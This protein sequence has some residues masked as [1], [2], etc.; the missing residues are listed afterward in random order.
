M[1]K[2]FTRRHFI[3]NGLRGLV[4]LLLGKGFYNSTSYNIELTNVKIQIPTLPA[5]FKG[6]RIAHLSDIHSSMIVSNGII[7][8]A[9]GLAMEQKPD[10]IFLT[11][12]FIS[13]STKFL[14][15]SIG[16]FNRK[17]LDR[18]I[19]ALD[20]LKAPMGIY[21]VLGNHDFWSGPKA[22][23][24]ITQEFSNR[25]GVIWLRNTSVKLERDGKYLDLLGIDDYWQSSSSLSKATK[26]LDEGS[27]KILLSHNPDINELIDMY[28]SKI[29]LVLSGHTH[30]GQ[31]VMP[32]IGM[33][34]MPSRTG[35]KYRE[36]LIRDG[37]RQT[38]VTRGIGHL[39]APIRINCPP[40]VTLI[41]LT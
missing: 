35:Q 27:I 41:T 37:D 11:G 7:S 5:P 38:Y 23:K 14:S 24:T 10:I 22:V 1:F 4:L 30:G 2:T 28:K 36:G 34:F 33:P 3:V 8:A 32:I 17:Y 9:S 15:G 12:D 20:G 26:G 13:G 6:L 18:C 19:D 21:A 31:I 40:E 39:L 25:L 29:D 16:E